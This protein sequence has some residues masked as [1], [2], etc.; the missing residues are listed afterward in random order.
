MHACNPSVTY[1]GVHVDKMQRRPGISHVSPCVE[2]IPYGTFNT[3]TGR[4]VWPVPTAFL[5]R[6]ILEKCEKFP[7]SFF[8]LL[9]ERKFNANPP[10][11][12]FVV[13][14]N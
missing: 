3:R 9:S 12:G 10:G 2:P 7:I 11:F 1:T 13:W 14:R 5:F 8:F 4:M 6:E